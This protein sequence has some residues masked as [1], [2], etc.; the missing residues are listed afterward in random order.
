MISCAPTPS[1]GDARVEALVQPLQGLLDQRGAALRE[2][3][4][5][6]RV[7]G[8]AGVADHLHAGLAHADLHRHLAQPD[9]VLGLQVGRGEKRRLAGL[10]EDLDRQ[11][12]AVEA[13]ADDPAEG[14][15]RFLLPA[16][17]PA[18]EVEAVEDAQVV[19]VG[20]RLGLAEQAIGLGRLVLGEGGLRLGDDRRGRQAQQVGRIDA[21]AGRAALARLDVGD[22][23]AVERPG[24]AVAEQRRRLG[25]RPW[26]AW[27]GRPAWRR[28]CRCAG[29]SAPGRRGRRRR[30]R[31]DGP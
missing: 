12:L 14:L 15:G 10:E 8:A 1:L 25:R 7:A 26:S 18:G 11:L 21:V 23:R 9:R 16:G 24:R 6:G 30:S 29:R 3:E 22:G 4:V 27:P 13:D 20:E 17:L 2:R 5:G 31:R 19:G 28:A